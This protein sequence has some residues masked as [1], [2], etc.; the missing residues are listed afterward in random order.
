MLAM[1]IM[2]TNI[3]E[4]QKRKKLQGNSSLR[5]YNMLNTVLMQFVAVLE[6]KFSYGKG[7][8]IL[9]RILDNVKISPLPIMATNF[10]K[11]IS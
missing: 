7:A 10:A 9:Q 6:L 2:W 4:H 11:Q 3:E 8:W 1:S 5:G